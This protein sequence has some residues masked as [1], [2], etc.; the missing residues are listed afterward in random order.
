MS[1][2]NNWL[3]LTFHFETK[4]KLFK[5]SRIYLETNLGSKWKIYCS[6][7]KRSKKDKKYED[8]LFYFC[9]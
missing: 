8:L 5:L 2:E 3:G 6:S 9:E 4:S 7:N 1:T